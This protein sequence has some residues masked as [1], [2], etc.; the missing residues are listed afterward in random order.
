MLIDS[1]PPEIP[2]ETPN[3]APAPSTTLIDGVE[4]PNWDCTEETALCY[5]R[6]ELA[7]NGIDETAPVTC[8]SKTIL[9]RLACTN[10]SPPPGQS[11]RFECGREDCNGYIAAFL[12]VPLV[13]KIPGALNNDPDDHREKPKIPQMY[14]SGPAYNGGANA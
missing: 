12:G 5:L 13:R 7:A 2:G 1:C 9:G 11:I 14:T 10:P 3:S 4:M 8:N 6:L